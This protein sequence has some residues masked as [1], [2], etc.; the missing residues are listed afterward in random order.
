MEILYTIWLVIS[1]F[2]VIFTLLFFY[3]F[4]KNLKAEVKFAESVKE[5]Q[6]NVKLVYV[7]TIGDRWMMYDKRHDQFI[8]QA[9][10][11]KELLETAEAMFPNM[12]VLLTTKDSMIN[13]GE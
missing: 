4:F 5:F 6:A 9:P 8:C 1:V 11:E 7:E 10:T 12:K 13:K 2:S 3:V